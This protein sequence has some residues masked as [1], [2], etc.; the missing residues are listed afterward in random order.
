MR[1][2]LTAR[3]LRLIAD[4]AVDTDG[5]G[6][7]AKRLAVSERHLHRQ[8]VEEVGAGPLMLARTR[9]AQT[10]RLLIESTTLPLTD[11]AFTAG[12]SSVRQFNDSMREAFGCT[13]SALRAGRPS[14]SGP[15]GTGAIVL[16]L[17]LRPPYDAG[18]LLGWLR[19]RAVH[20]IEQVDDTGY[21]R[22]I[23]LPR[24]SGVLELVPDGDHSDDAARRRRRSSTSPAAVARTRALADLDADPD[25]V[26]EVL[27]E[28]PLLRPLVAARPGLRVP[29]HVDGFELGCRAVLG[30][31]VSVAGARTL[32]RPAGGRGG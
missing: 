7:L 21:R 3:A 27:A 24:T 12:Y 13:P 28:D 16:R 14:R 22:T 23:R 29:G 20:G 1:A 30:Q 5:V 18:A 2:D 15:P 11:I 19:S 9:R 31:Q 6:G 32:L 17:A 25:A 10:A 26:G 8:L 4:G